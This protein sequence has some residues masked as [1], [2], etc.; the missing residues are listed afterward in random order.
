[1]EMSN[2]GKEERGDIKKM[3]KENEN[4]MKVSQGNF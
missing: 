1:M 2:R 3:E 4:K